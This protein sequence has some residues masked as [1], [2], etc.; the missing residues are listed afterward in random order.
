MRSCESIKLISEGLIVKAIEAEINVRK[1]YISDVR[2]V[3]KKGKRE[4][5]LQ[6]RGKIEDSMGAEGENGKSRRLGPVYGCVSIANF[7]GRPLSKRRWFGG[8]S[9]N[10]RFPCIPP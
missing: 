9:S 5:D 6:G 1:R 4:R 7:W 10:R 2:V 3:N 8:P